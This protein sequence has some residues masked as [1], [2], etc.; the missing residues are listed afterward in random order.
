MV[1]KLNM[2]STDEPT[3]WIRVPPAASIVSI[4]ILIASA[5]SWGSDVVEVQYSIYGD[6]SELVDGVETSFESARSFESP[7]TFTSAS[8]SRTSIP[9]GSV[10]FIRLIPTTASGAGDPKALVVC[11]FR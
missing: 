11:G 1:I 8:P 3:R 4:D 5:F 2:A 10:G 9:V 6:H 7:V